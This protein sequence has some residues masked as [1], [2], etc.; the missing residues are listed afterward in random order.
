[1]SQ[2]AEETLMEV[3]QEDIVSDEDDPVVTEVTTLLSSFRLLDSN[4]YIAF[5][6][7]RHG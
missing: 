1:M 2:T 7:R 6:R 5:E 3:D 4:R